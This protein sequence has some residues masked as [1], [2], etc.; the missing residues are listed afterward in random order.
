MSLG[1]LVMSLTIVILVGRFK[2]VLIDY[3]LVFLLIIKCIGT[4]YLVHLVKNKVSGF[5]QIDAKEL[6][7]QIP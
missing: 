5:E 6:I 3:A 7:D 2:K 1:P 4:L